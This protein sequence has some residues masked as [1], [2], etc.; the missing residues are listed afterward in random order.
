M[1]EIS[2]LPWNGRNVI[3]TFSGGGGSSLG[4]RMAGCRVL[5]ANE[6]VES[7]RD[8][9][10]ANA[11]STIIDPRDIR[12]IKGQELLDRVGLSTGELDIFDGSPPCASFSMSGKREK[13]WGTVKT[14]S[15]TSQQS[16]DLFFE[17]ARLV[18]EIQPR[19]FIAEN[20]KGLV[21]GK[22]RGYFK[23][24]LRRLKA[25]GYRVTARVLDAAWLGVPQRRNR[26]IFIGIREDLG[27]DPVFPEPLP[28]QYTVRDAI[29]WVDRVVHDTSGDW[30]EGDVT[31]RPSPTITVGV[32]SV[33]SY[34]FKVV[35]K[36]ASAKGT[37]IE[38]E[39]QTLKPGEGSDKYLNLI[40]AHAEK[41][42][43]SVTASAGG[44]GTAGVMHPFECRKFSIEEL[45]RICSFPDDF[46]LTGP[47]VKQWERCGRAVPPVMMSHIAAAV[48]RSLDENG[49]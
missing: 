40:K 13:G 25:C 4:Y 24:I 17:Y 41:P 28:Y 10:Q 18:R 37:A 47:Y 26:V 12:E 27:F 14:Y 9:Y 48:V 5:L 16:D 38:K 7:A 42:S 3:S 39:Y 22:A 46:V 6:F 20:V 30:G 2:S 36:E 35:E 11:P 45:K 23:L 29:P 15:E 8:T 44:R 1:E 33:N 32:N 34:H 31:D 49:V 21:I 19:A 43:P